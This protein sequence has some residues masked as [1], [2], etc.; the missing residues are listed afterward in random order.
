MADGP[1]LEVCALTVRRA[2]R[3]VLRAVD[4]HVERGEILAIVGP[5]GPAASLLLRCV[6]RMAE[7]EPGVTVEG[8]VL[9]DGLDVYA[10][11]V[12]PVALRRR[13]GLLLR[14]PSPLPMFSIRDN[15]LAGYRLAGE[16]LPRAAELVEAMLQRVG[17]WERVRERLDASPFVLG[18]DAQLRLCLARCLA[19]RPEVILLDDPA[20]SLDP[21]GTARFEELVTE[22]RAE[23]AIVVVTSNLQ[24]AARVADTAALLLE[25]ALVER[26]PSTQFFTNPRDPRTEDY[27]TGRFG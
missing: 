4:L 11:S 20:A 25:G 26:A 13:V 27:L 17:L 22:L 9:L 23:A 1:K 16:R 6:N 24:Q 15:V 2:E 21:A 5:S 12:D 10:S 19:L 18:P 8:R 7:L 14:E 3:E